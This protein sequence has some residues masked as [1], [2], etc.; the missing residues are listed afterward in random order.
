MDFAQNFIEASRW[1]GGF[2]LE[3]MRAEK[4]DELF[5]MEINPRFPAWIYTTAAAG[6]NL[7]GAIVNLALDRPQEAFGPY[8]VGKIFIRYSWELITDISEYQ[9]IATTGELYKTEKLNF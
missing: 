8:E 9:Q 4:D 6:Q 2:E 3:I 5:L 7:P 1:P